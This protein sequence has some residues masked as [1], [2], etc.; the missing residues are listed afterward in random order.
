MAAAG[1]KMD[2]DGAGKGFDEQLYNRQEYAIGADA[3]R[4]LGSCDVLIVGMSGLGMEVAKDVALTGVHSVTLFDPEQVRWTDLSSCFYFGEADVGKNRVDACL[5][6][7]QALNQYCV[8]SK[9]SGDVLSNEL[10]EEWRQG[11]LRE[12]AH[13]QQVIV[14]TDQ[15]LSHCKDLNTFCRE[16]NIKFVGAESRGLAGCVFVDDGPRHVV[17]DTDGEDPKTCIITGL[18]SECPAMVKVHEDQR[19]EMGDGDAVLFFDLDDFPELNNPSPDVRDP[20]VFRV[21]TTGVY[22]FTI[23]TAGEDGELVPVDGAKLARYQRGGFC[24]RVKLP[25]EQSFLSLAEAI[26]KPEMM[27]TDFAKEDEPGTLHLLFLALHEYAKR[28]GGMPSPHNADQADAVLGIAKDIAKG[29]PDMKPNEDVIKRLAAVAAGN[30]CPMAAMLGG[31]TAHEVLKAASGK[32]SPIKQW[33]YFDAR[34]CLLDPP[35]APES[36]QPSGSRYDGAVAI[37]GKE[38]QEKLQK[39]NYFCVGAGAL[40]CEFLKTYAMLGVGCH[41]EGAVTV[42][43]MDSIEKSNLSRQFLFRNT[44]VGRQKSECAAAAAKAMNPQLNIRHLNEKVGS[45]TEHI[46]DDAFWEKL[47]GVTNALDNVMAR[48]YVDS[49]CIQFRKPLLESGTLGSK[50]NVQVV[51]PD[52]TESYGSSRDPPEKSIPICTLKNFPNA[53][54]H[55]IQWARDHFSGLFQC[56]STDVNSYIKSP[57]YLQ[58][59]E[60]DPGNQVATLE[61]ILAATVTERPRSFADCVTWARMKFEELFVNTIA[62]ILHN[63]PIDYRSPSGDLFWS[64]PKRPP[65]PAKFDP[66]DPLHAQFCISAANLRAYMFGIAQMGSAETARVV[67]M[68]AAVPV[69]EFKPRK[70]KIQTDEKEKVEEDPLVAP[71]LSREQIISQLPPQ[72]DASSSLMLREIEFEKDDDSNWHMDFITACSNLRARNYKIPEADKTK[73][74]MIAGKIIPAMVTTTALVTGLVGFELLKLHQGN[75]KIDAYKNGFLNL[76]IPFCTLSEPMPCPE[77]SFGEDG[78]HKFTLWS[79][80]DVD[81]GKDVLLGELLTYFEKRYGLEVEM[82]S[83]GTCLLYNGY[84]ASARQ[85]KGMPVAEILKQVTKRDPLPTQTKIVLE[86]NAECDGEEVEELPSVVYKFRGW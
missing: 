66:A 48:L 60:R 56:V 81:L 47:D 84:G 78:K 43:D 73:T 69:P 52:M 63:L 15:C 40:G 36:C 22:T 80:F 82:I 17:H 3:Q 38:Y 37:F 45:D 75:K 64:G 42:T 76:A 51:V 2:V 35:P 59:L 44:N 41:S 28:S 8:V 18:T 50:G 19:H 20:K 85:R 11:S 24:V 1:D 58:Q 21:K 23:H 86:V 4:K 74:K 9:L 54:E 33:M 77:K 65:T 13:A 12:Q 27:P 26:E 31:F 49:R 16:R 71:A 10:V 39:L 62:Q 61:S 55:T 83:A 79:R 70:A 46:F 68:A 7:L 57:G 6:Q 32:F 5:S 30:I 34:E 14:L 29:F 67:E 72:G 25:V 53:I